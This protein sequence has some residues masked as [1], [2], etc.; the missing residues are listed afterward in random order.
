MKERLVRALA[1]GGVRLA[2]H[3]GLY[4]PNSLNE[5]LRRLFVRRP[6]GLVV[7][8]GAHVGEYGMRLRQLGFPGDILSFEPVP[9][10]YQRLRDRIGGDERWSAVRCAAGDR[11]ET[12]LMHIPDADDLA[13]L[14]PPSEYAH[15]R[16]GRSSQVRRT[17]PVETRR[18]DTILTERFPDGVRGEI[19]L[20]VD[21]QG[22]DL[23]VVE[24]AQN[25]LTS[26]TAIQIELGILSLYEQAVA[27]PQAVARLSELGYDLGAIFPV[28]RDVDELRLV[29]VD[30]VFVRRPSRERR[31]D[32]GGAHARSTR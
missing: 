21:A 3:A 18:I 9:E 15:Q 1:R 19:L 12:R 6:I 13:S 27:F 4:L 25:A 5:Y 32:A 16:F 7:D 14:L 8:V 29:D 11:D 24:G 28:L 10:T 2:E 26:I 31:D 30:C 22:A 17:T 23:A 20:K